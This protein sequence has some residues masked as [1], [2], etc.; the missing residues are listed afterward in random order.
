[1]KF[2]MNHTFFKKRQGFKRPFFILLYCSQAFWPGDQ[3]VP[4]TIRPPGQYG[5]AYPK[6]LFAAAPVFVYLLWGRKALADQL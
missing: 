2:F 1:M 3:V 4:L 5:C 6:I